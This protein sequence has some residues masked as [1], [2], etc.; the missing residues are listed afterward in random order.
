ML[1][2]PVPIVVLERVGLQYDSQA[3]YANAEARR[4]GAEVWHAMEAALQPQ[5]EGA[6]TW[7]DGECASVGAWVGWLV[8]GWVGGCIWA[9]RRPEAMARR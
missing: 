9:C 4:L 1:A 3:C 2:L 7:L 5:A 6:A 8:G